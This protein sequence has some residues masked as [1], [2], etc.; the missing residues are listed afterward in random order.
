MHGLLS[1]GLY[2]LQESKSVL[3]R[4]A[5]LRKENNMVEIRHPD[6]VTIQENGRIAV[7]SLLSGPNGFAKIT[8][9]WN[10]NKL[11]TVNLFKST[12]KTFK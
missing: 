6:W 4:G 7:D 9:I 11:I 10:D 12:W 3:F 1:Y 5:S 2:G 8:S